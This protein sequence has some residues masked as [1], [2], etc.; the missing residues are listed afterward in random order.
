MSNLRKIICRV[1]QEQGR[2]CGEKDK[3]EASC[4]SW[5]LLVTT[6]WNNCL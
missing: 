2:R 5:H 1:F 3:L 4:G 6:E